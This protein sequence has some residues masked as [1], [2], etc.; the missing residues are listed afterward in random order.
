MSHIKEELPR[1]FAWER[2]RLPAC[3]WDI[4][5]P[6][7]QRTA[8]HVANTAGHETCGQAEHWGLSPSGH[9]HSHDVPSL[10]PPEPH[11]RD[12]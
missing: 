2:H 1:L 7:G 5:A 11:G 6:G 10:S 12:S 4:S 8:A 3:A 9:R